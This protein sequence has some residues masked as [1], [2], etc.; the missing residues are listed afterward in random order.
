MPRRRTALSVTLTSI[1]AGVLIGA[2][3]GLPAL[4]GASSNP[5][6]SSPNASSP[7][8]LQHGGVKGGPA[9]GGPGA[10]LEAAAE[11]L[12]MTTDELRQRLSDGT[13][14]IADIAREKNVDVNAVIDAIAADQRARI[15]EFVNNPL[16]LRDHGPGNRPFKGGGFRFGGEKF[17]AAVDALGGITLDELWEAIRDGKSIADIARDK[18]VDVQ[19]VI[20][21]MVEAAETA[22]DEAQ[23]S[24]IVTEEQAT[25]MKDG[26]EEQI[27]RIVNGE[28]PDFGW[29]R[30]RGKT[31]P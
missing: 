5:N 20:D 22:I 13:T 24:G 25:R 1:V 31:G 21:A 8:A 15:E 18:G 16:R 27:T 28:F 12:G 9:A 14:S 11:A 30:G 6:G 4:S 29:G 19:T 3:F 17:E 7:A 26:L 10:A 2:W 23:A